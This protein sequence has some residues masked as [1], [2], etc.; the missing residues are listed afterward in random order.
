[1]ENILVRRFVIEGFSAA[2][3]RVPFCGSEG[4]AANPLPMRF[5][6]L[7][8]AMPFCD[9]DA[10][11]CGDPTAD[12]VCDAGGETCAFSATKPESR[13]ALTVAMMLMFAGS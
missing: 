2:G 10:C 11:D 3:G 4:G 6:A 7:G 5:S 8:T 9:V 1:V 13:G 12:D